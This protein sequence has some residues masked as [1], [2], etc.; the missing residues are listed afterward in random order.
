MYVS[1]VSHNKGFIAKLQKKKKEKVLVCFKRK[2]QKEIYDYNFFFLT[3][4]S[5]LQYFQ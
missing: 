3:K 4:R 5:Y 2:Q 1:A